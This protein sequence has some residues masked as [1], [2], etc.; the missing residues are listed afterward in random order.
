MQIGITEYG[1][2]GIDFRWENRTNNLD[3]MILIT[4]NLNAVFQKK[5]LK[6]LKELPIII[7]CTCTGWGNT[8]MEPNVPDYFT[9]LNWLADFIKMGFPPE[10]IVLRIDP[11]FPTARGLKRALCMIE[12]FKSLNLPVSRFRMSIVDEYPHVRQRYIERGFTPIY[13]GNFQPSWSQRQLVAEKLA[14]TGLQFATCAEDALAKNYPETFYIKG[15]ISNDDLQI[16]GIEP[17]ISLFENPQ[18]RTGC[19]CLS[20]KTELL[21]NPRKKCPHDCLYCFWKNFFNTP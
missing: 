7:H 3:G 8:V 20:C 16:M 10:N 2:A 15:C 18:R 13:N 9:Q 19:H 5:V 21:N 12:Y 11:I 1:D 14:T 6:K 4:K 17:D